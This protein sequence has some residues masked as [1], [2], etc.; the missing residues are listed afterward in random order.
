MF[1]QAITLY[2]ILL[3]GKYEIKKPRISPEM[4]PRTTSST[5]IP[6]S[7]PISGESNTY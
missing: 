7:S 3:W 1:L 5:A 2:F 6:I 4:I